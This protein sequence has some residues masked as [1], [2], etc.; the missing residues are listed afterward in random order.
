MFH[1][2]K[3]SQRQRKQRQRKH[4]TKA[5][6]CCPAGHEQEEMGIKDIFS[7]FEIVAH[8]GERVWLEEFRESCEQC[9]EERRA[10][11]QK[12]EQEKLDRKEEEERNQRE[13]LEQKQKEDRRLRK[14]FRPDETWVT[15]HNVVYRSEDEICRANF[16]ALTMEIS[17]DYV[18]FKL[19]PREDVDFKEVSDDTGWGTSSTFLNKTDEGVC[20]VAVARDLLRP[21]SSVVSLGKKCKPGRCKDPCRHHSLG[22]EWFYDTWRGW[23]PS[24]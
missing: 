6:L 10:W 8:Q 21:R 4:R 5:V 7:K 17:D 13:A 11:K 22:Q 15:I 3:L 2:K 19:K 20:Y 24:L 9:Q 23:T 18:F 1:N 16:H 12:R 14:L